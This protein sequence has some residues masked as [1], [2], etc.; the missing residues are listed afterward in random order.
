DALCHTFGTMATGGFST[1]NASIGAY[2]PY[3]QW[4]I[5][6]FMFLAGVN[7]MLHYQAL[8]G[9]IGGYFR[10][11]EFRWYLVLVIACIFI[12][13]AVLHIH[14]IGSSPLLEASFQTV[15]IITT[16]GYVTANFD[17]WPQAL[18]FILIVL[19]FIGGC[20]GSTGGG[21]K[22][23]RFFLSLKIALRSIM[24]ALFP[25]AVLPVRF[26][27]APQADRIVTSVLS[28]FVIYILLFFS[29]TVVM[30]I[31]ERCDL[32]TAFSASIAC[33]SNIGPGLGKVGADSNYAWISL[34]GKW[35][36]SFLMLAGRLEL[37]SI[38]VLFI[39]S[40]WKK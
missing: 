18:R 35:F 30:T 6:F 16:T 23:I 14:S 36:L 4:V 1:K 34:P 7:F 19:M 12:F 2:G 32:V 40:T 8:R 28:Y 21:M 29:G 25:N 26:N 31:T 38:L 10:N 3:I 22:I 33:L 13:T 5:T 24:Q 27:K 15:S 20:G 11:E 39:P 17:L 9:K 37:Y